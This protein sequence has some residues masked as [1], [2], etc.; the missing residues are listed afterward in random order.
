MFSCPLNRFSYVSKLEI[1]ILLLKNWKI[2]HFWSFD[3]IFLTISMIW[4]R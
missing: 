1:L 3:V 4:S 2:T